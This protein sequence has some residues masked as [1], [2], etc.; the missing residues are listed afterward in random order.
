MPYPDEQYV[1]LRLMPALFGSLLVPLVYLLAHRGSRSQMAA[2]VAGVFV[3][4]ENALLVQSKFI[5][6]DSF[7]LVFGFLSLYLFWQSTTFFADGRWGGKAAV[8]SAVAAGLCI[9]TKWTG[10]GFWGLL[11]AF[12][13]YTVVGSIRAGE[14]RKR[15][16][17]LACAA[18]LVAVPPVLYSA[19]F[20]TH[21]ALL[22]QPG[23]GNRSHVA[24]IPGVTGCRIPAARL[25]CQPVGGEP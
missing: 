4:F 16:A 22:P 25:S 19:I 5:L 1:W 6:L 14:H 10:I 11:L 23:P 3:L 15:G 2:G 13:C 7:L 9:A 12:A 21:F 24:P 18:L 20:L 8:G 17:V